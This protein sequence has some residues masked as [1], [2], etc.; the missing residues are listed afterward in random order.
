MSMQ[1]YSE[2]KAQLQD[3]LRSQGHSAEIV[4]IFQE[5]VV[6]RYQAFLIKTPLD[7]ENELIAERIYNLGI[8]RGFGVCLSAFAIRDSRVCCYVLLPNDEED[9]VSLLI[10]EGLKISIS[11]DLPT[12]TTTSSS[13]VWSWNRILQR[14]A[15]LPQYLTNHPSKDP[16][17][18]PLK[19]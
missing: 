2:A 7:N 15:G 4:W 17:S 5:D 9:A 1:T 19:T 11:C 8:E 13:L 18:W 12:A 16:A 14:L 6:P 10:G 3:F